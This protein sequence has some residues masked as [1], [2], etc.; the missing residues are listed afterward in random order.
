MRK[1]IIRAVGLAAAMLA[2]FIKYLHSPAKFC[3]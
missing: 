1:L 3:L 2:P